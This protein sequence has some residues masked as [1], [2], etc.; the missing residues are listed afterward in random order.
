[1]LGPNATEVLRAMG[2]LDDVMA[3]VDESGKPNRSAWIQTRLGTEGS[4]LVYNVSQ[5]GGLSAVSCS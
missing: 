4:E 1:M 2:I 5:M 3:K